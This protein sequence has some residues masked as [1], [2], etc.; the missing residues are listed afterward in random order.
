EWTKRGLVLPT[1]LQV[2]AELHGVTAPNLAQAIS[3]VHG[4]VV[5][6]KRSIGSISEADAVRDLAGKTDRR[7]EI[8]LHRVRIQQW[9]I[10]ARSGAGVPATGAI[11]PDAIPGATNVELVG[12]GRRKRPSVADSPTA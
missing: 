9:K 8:R 12:H 7:Q 4:R 3:D 6:D 5:I 11:D 10:H 1:A 2:H